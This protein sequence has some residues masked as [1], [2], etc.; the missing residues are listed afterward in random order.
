MSAVLLLCRSAGAE[1]DNWDAVRKLEPHLPKDIVHFVEREMMCIHWAGEEPYDKAR[2]AEIGQA[3]QTLRCQTLDGEEKALRKKY[4]GNAK[5]LHALDLAGN[6][7]CP[8]GK[9]CRL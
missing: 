7:D 2:A 8:A 4:Q 9:K 1:E 3:V 5:I 6:A